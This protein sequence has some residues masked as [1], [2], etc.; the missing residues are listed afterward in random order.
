ML[1]RTRIRN[2]KETWKCAHLEASVTAQRADLDSTLPG[3]GS[4]GILINEVV[5]EGLVSIGR[6]DRVLGFVQPAFSKTG[7]Q[8]VG[9]HRSGG[10]LE[11][12]ALLSRVRLVHDQ[13][14]AV[15]FRVLS[16]LETFGDSLEVA[17]QALVTGVRLG[18]DAQ[19]FDKRP[20]VP[21]D[22]AAPDDGS[23]AVLGVSPDGGLAL[24]VTVED[25]VGLGI[26]S[27]LGDL[28]PLKNDIVCNI[29]QQR[30]VEY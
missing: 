20:D 28:V 18:E 11:V 17:K 23:D 21:A 22:C 24:V 10:T 19:N 16:V 6:R 4:V 14:P 26:V 25:E 9:E 12:V 1:A 30:R 2:C 3:K 13:P 7:K 29:I 5:D 27:D 8:T 15:R